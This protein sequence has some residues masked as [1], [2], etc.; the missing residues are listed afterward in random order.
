ML[1]GTLENFSLIGHMLSFKGHTHDSFY[2]LESNSFK[3]QAWVQIYNHVAILL[4]DGKQKK[5]KKEKTKA[6]NSIGKSVVIRFPIHK[7]WLSSSS[8]SEKHPKFLS[9]L[10]A[11]KLRTFISV[12]INSF[13]IKVILHPTADFLS[14]NQEVLLIIF[15]NT[16][17]HLFILSKK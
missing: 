10:H 1:L 5:K 16:R 15:E 14:V 4:L 13:F 6:S 12:H 2:S 17:G 9:F 11:V 8:F 7:T 3:G